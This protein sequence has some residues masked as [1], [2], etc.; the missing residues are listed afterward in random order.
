[1]NITLNG[2]R[3]RLFRSSVTMV[4]ITVA[5][6]FL[7]NILTESLIKTAL[8]TDAVERLADHRLPAFWVSRLTSPAS[9]EALLLQIADHP[10]GSAHGREIAEFGGLSDREMEA[11]HEQAGIGAA[12]IRL[13]ADLD[14]GR[15][16]LLTGGNAGLAIFEYLRDAGNFEAYTDHLTGMQTLRAPSSN[17]EFRG[18][19]EGWPETQ[20][21]ILQ[22]R[23]GQ[24]SAIAQVRN[25]LGGRRLAVALADAGGGFGDTIREAGFTTLDIS[26]AEKLAR[27]STLELTAEEVTASLE[28]IEVRRQVAVRLNILPQE[29]SSQV[30]WPALN[31]GD[32][33]G[34]FAGLFA[35]G[36]LDPDV[37]SELAAQRIEQQQLTAIEPLQAEIGGGFMGM[38][39]R[40]TWLI[41]LSLVVCVVG[42]ANA[43]LMSVTERYREIATFKC[44]GALDG[45][46]MLIFIIEAS[47]LGSVGGMLG[48]IAGG[49]L[50]ILSM[51]FTHGGLVFA[52]IP[53][54]AL[55]FCVLISIGAGLL[56]AS[57]AS[58]Y[59]S[60]K[61]ARLAPMEAMR[62]E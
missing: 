61:A 19:L 40:I 54:L 30:L 48:A 13:F 2:V 37:L 9:T 36:R 12:Y 55:L 16:R 58:I 21:K 56:L 38:G 11:L 42:I 34:W 14:Y 26:T 7:M 32:G 31:R 59:P 5:I 4:V 39:E 3:Y 33:A 15:Q 57:L 46:I 50:G 45:S 20:A 17:E 43:M 28:P 35:E 24:Q 23:N 18:F 22:I 10:P 27:Q 6:A 25:G 51:I 52:S 44:L 47:L 41:L 53:L 8:V 49:L 29:V 60:Q 62:I 1:M